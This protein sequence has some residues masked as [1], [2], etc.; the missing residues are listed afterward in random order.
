MAN[1]HLALDDAERAEEYVEKIFDL[2]AEN[3]TLYGE[4]LEYHKKIDSIRGQPI[5]QRNVTTEFE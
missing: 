2:D 1:A 4:I 5:W 3:E